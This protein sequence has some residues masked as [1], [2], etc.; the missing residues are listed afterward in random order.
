[1]E[2]HSKFRS[3]KTRPDLQVSVTQ[4]NFA[5]SSFLKLLKY[6]FYF[7]PVFPTISY[8][9]HLVYSQRKLFPYLKFV[10]TLFKLRCN[11]PEII[12]GQKFMDFS[13]SP[14]V[15]IFYFNALIHHTTTHSKIDV[16]WNFAMLRSRR[17]IKNFFKIFICINMSLLFSF[18]SNFD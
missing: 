4:I 13:Y 17:D 15:Q 2:P 11:F 12:L 8:I 9:F 3:I 5:F 1:M 16:H 7:F 18:Y 14:K 10:C 6:I